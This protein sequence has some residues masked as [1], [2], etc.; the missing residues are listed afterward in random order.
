MN[1]RVTYFVVLN[2][3]ITN[4][5]IIDSSHSDKEMNEMIQGITWALNKLERK[6]YVDRDIPI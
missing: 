4:V 2:N 1:L 5:K 6:D 3:F